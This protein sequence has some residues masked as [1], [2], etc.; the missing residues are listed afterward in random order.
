MDEGLAGRQRQY[1]GWIHNLRKELN[2]YKA[3]NQ[4]L[5]GRLRELCGPVGQQQK[6]Y[7]KGN[8]SRG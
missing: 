2:H 3:A 7:A 4:E 6:D 5:S 8:Q 1:E